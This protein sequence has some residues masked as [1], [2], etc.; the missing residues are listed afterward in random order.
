[1]ALT[2]NEAVQA[3]TI[4]LQECD[5][6]NAYRM[7]DT[8]RIGYFLKLSFGNKTLEADTRVRDPQDPDKE[9][10]VVVVIDRLDWD[11]LPTSYFQ[12]SGRV[13][14]KNRALM[15]EALCSSNGKFELEA[16][17]VFYEYDYD[18]GK[19]FRSFYTNQ[20]GVKLNFID[21]NRVYIS[22][23]PDREI[24][25]PVNFMFDMILQPDTESTGQK[26][27]CAFS[28]SGTTFSRP[29]GPE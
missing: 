16:E 4:F 19:Y 25:L 20:K 3:L 27:S 22:P 6:R 21:G 29:V 17:W 23:K 26:L 11:G 12:I 5:S 10:N 15:Q 9:I 28:A 24:K 14:S 7:C 8:T 13:S 18:E 1:M 2:T